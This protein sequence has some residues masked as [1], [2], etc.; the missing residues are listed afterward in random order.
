AYWEAYSSAAE[1]F[2]YAS[3]MQYGGDVWN[4]GYNFVSL[5]AETNADISAGIKHKSGIW[6]YQSGLAAEYGMTETAVNFSAFWR[7][8]MKIDYKKWRITPAANIYWREESA[9]MDFQF[10]IKYRF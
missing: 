9:D 2:S 7:N 10:N 6:E 8:A 3:G 1:D 5:K 4:A